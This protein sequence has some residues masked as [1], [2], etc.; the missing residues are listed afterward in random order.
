MRSKKMFYMTNEGWME[1]LNKLINYYTFYIEMRDI[2]PEKDTQTNDKLESRNDFFIKQY[3]GSIV[4]TYS[5]SMYNLCYNSD[6]TLEWFEWFIDYYKIPA[7]W[8]E[9]DL[10]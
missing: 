6:R 10:P 3:T 2:Y 4:T 8:N 1:M 9:E 7:Y 5:Y